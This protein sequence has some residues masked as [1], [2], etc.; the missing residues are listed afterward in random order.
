MK[1]LLRLLARISSRLRLRGWTAT[2]RELTELSRPGAPSP[3]G[4]AES[5]GDGRTFAGIAGSVPLP[6]PP[7]KRPPQ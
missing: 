1:K 6:E 2:D 7:A 3:A 5:R 4:Y